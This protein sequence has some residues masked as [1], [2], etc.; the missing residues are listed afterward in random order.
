MTDEEALRLH[1]RA[2]LGESLTEEERAELDTWYAAQD[3][4]EARDLAAARSEPVDLTQRI[5]AALEQIAETTRHMQQ[6]PRLD[7]SP[8][9]RLLA[10]IEERCRP[11]A[12]W[13]FGSRAKGTADPESDWDL[14]VILPDS[15]PFEKQDDVVDAVRLR[16]LSQVNADILTCSESD[17]KSAT[18][19]PNTLAYEVARTGIPLYEH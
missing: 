2:A 3:A 17:F 15:V 18:S 16:S 11:A 1:D 13:L 10:L 6:T 8:I 14:L 19:I 9:K 5:Q 12:V 7:L 4:A